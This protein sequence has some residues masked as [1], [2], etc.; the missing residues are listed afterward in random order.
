MAETPPTDPTI[1]EDSAGAIA[2]RLGPAGVLGVVWAVLPALGGFVLLANLGP[3]SA[4]LNEHRATG[5]AVYVLVFI[6][7]AGFGLLPTYSQAILAGYAFGVVAG[8]PAA[9]AGF[10]GA[11]MVGWVIA[12]RVSAGRVDEEIRR[13]RRLALVRDALV[14]HGFGRALGLVAL[15][16]VPP[17]S[18]FALTNLVLSTSGVA[19]GPYVLGTALGML[20][21]TVAAVAIGA[22]IEGALDRDAVGAPL[23]LKIAGIVVTL[24]VVA[25]IGLIAQRILDRVTRGGATTPHPSERP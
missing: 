19:R 24:V 12:R 7:S 18:P 2:R 11:A 10:V 14:R 8:V 23:W 20:P 1:A 3:V 16:R 13:H 25:V 22:Q 21:R 9:L 6:F 4:F 15:V 17:N 5:L